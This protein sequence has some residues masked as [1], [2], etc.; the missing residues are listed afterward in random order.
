[1]QILF[2]RVRPAT[3]LKPGIFPTQVLQAAWLLF[4]PVAWLA[5]L[6]HEC[7]SKT[8]Q[9]AVALPLPFSVTSPT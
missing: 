6:Q 4:V 1:V 3:T 5:V 2:E 9:E 8:G 7:H